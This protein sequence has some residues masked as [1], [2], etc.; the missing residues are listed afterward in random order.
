MSDVQTAPGEADD[1]DPFAV[2][3]ESVGVNQIRDPHPTFHAL[4]SACPVQ[5]GGL[6]QHFDLDV[7]ATPVLDTE[8]PPHAVLSF[9]GVQQVL[10]DGETFS[11]SA[12]ADS[13][14]IVMGHSI[15]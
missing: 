7:P 3:D 2:F 6:A 4:R 8:S 12:Y 15:L 13:M 11:S 10:K 9:D 14:G 5:P 1:Y